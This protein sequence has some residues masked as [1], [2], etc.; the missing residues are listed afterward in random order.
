MLQLLYC[1]VYYRP[2]THP[3]GEGIGCEYSHTENTV[4]DGTLYIQEAGC[5]PEAQRLQRE[6]RDYLLEQGRALHQQALPA[7]ATA[8]PTDP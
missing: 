4:P 6:E 1:N 5:V 3:N 7:A 2:A 8:D